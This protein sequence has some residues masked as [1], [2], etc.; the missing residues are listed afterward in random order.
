MTDQLSREELTAIIA[1]VV[2]TMTTK[3]TAKPSKK[4][5]YVRRD[6]KVTDL[7]QEIVEADVAYKEALNVRREAHKT[8]SLMNKKLTNLI[9][10]SRRLGITQVQL[11]EALGISRGAV[12]SR[13]N[14]ARRKHRKH[15]KTGATTK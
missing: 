9:V 11:A 1:E 7:L 4:R 14:T 5:K 8:A 10:E 3:P 2:A 6:V 12:S 13:V 15:S